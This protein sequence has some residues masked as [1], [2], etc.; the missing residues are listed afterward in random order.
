MVF[1]RPSRLILR[2]V[3]SLILASA[4]LWAA[5]AIWIDGPESRALAGTLAGALIL[6]A[7]TA[8]LLIRPRRRAMVAV[9][10]PFVLVLAWWLMLEPGNERDWQPNV[11]RLPSATIDGSRLRVRNVR[12]FDYRD[13]TDF[14]ER[15]ETRTYDLDT[16]IGFDMFVSFWGPTLYGHTIAS[17]AFADGRHLAISIETRKET[18]EAYSAMLG[19]FRQY[20]LYYVVADERDLIGLRADHR[21]ETVQLYRIGGDMGNGRHLLLDY[22]KEINAVADQP[23]WYNALSRNC[24]TTIWQ[25]TR[26]VGSG[27]RLDWRLLANGYLVDLAYERGTVNTDVPLEELKRRSDVTARARS[28]EDRENFSEVIRKDLPPRPWAHGSASA[29]E[30]GDPSRPAPGND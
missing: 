20:E 25:H 10:V 3:V 21:G 18:D 11:A 5:A 17:W 24:T 26:T 4:V 6:I 22:V 13:E 2:L 27:P 15:W 9:F 14:T 19:F 29:A 28:A 1:L 8:A 16:L 30:P 7:V 23:R 12:N